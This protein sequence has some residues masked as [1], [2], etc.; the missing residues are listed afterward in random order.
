MTGA[1]HITFIAYW[2]LG[3]GIVDMDASQAEFLFQI[4]MSVHGNS[5]AVVITQQREQSL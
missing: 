1:R 4:K 2:R 5:V 3:M